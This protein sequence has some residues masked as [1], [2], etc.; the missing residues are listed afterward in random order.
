MPAELLSSWPVVVA[1]V[2]VA[3]VLFKVV[4]VAVKLALFVL[5]L[6]ALTVG[7]G[8]YVKLGGSVALPVPGQA[9]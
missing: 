9:R 2:V 3:V 4:K 1:A 8:A 6:G 5:V 7:V